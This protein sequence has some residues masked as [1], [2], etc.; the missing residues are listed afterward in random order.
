MKIMHCCLA[1]FYIDGF[2]YQENILPRAHKQMGHEVVITASTETYIDGTKRAYVAPSHYM[3]E[4]G[5]EVVR[6]PYVTWLP[7]FLARKLRIY[8]GLKARLNDFQPDV[9]FLHDLQFLGIREIRTYARKSGAKVFVDSHTDGINSAKGW[10]SRY[11]L[12]GII[13]RYCARTITPV[14]EMFFPTL[15]ARMDFMNEVYGVA[16]A[17][18][19]LLPFGVDDIDVSP[20]LDEEDRLHLRRSLGIDDS[21][22]AIIAGGKIDS[23]KH[24]LE[25]MRAFGM[26]QRNIKRKIKLIIFGMPDD[27][28]ADEFNALLGQRGI[29]HV[30]WLAP[31]EITRVLQVSDLAVFPGTHS[32][33]WEEAVGLGVPCV[34]RRWAGISHVDIGGNCEMIDSASANDLEV[35]LTRLLSDPLTLAT[36]KVNA[37]QRQRDRFFYS[38][39]AA[40][41]IDPRADFDVV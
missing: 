36:M 4:D 2:G 10:L 23:R 31:N 12:H 27:E 21:D 15:P 14:T 13:Y 33:L 1:A 38:N 40:M 7:A 34:F 17:K 28:C 9:I 8:N 30:G 32:V 3:S 26:I 11:F 29:I 16:R 24:I 5:I 35:V 18:M 41:A 22:I 25:L 19:R 6:L 39:I 20:F 37:T